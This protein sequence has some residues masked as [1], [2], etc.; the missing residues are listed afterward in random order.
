MVRGGACLPAVRWHRLLPA[1]RIGSRAYV[2][3][4][5]ADV[6]FA[7][8]GEALALLAHAYGPEGVRRVIVVVVVRT[9]LN[10]SRPVRVLSWR[11]GP[12]KTTRRSAERDQAEEWS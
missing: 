4:W 1:G 9:D 10:G 5:V 7:H 12:L 6:P 3:V 8:D 11:E 2:V